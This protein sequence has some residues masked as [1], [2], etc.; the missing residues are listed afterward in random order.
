MG[1]NSRVGNTKPIKL[2]MDMFQKVERFKYLGTRISNEKLK[3]K[4]TK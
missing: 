4:L 1:R 2:A 3:T